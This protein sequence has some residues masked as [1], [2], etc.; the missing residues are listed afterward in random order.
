MIHT[1]A[2]YFLLTTVSHPEL[3]CFLKVYMSSSSQMLLG[4]VD[5]L[6][7]LKK[8]LGSLEEKQQV[9]KHLSAHI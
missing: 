8:G 9:A 5:A 6:R 7:A 1:E 4:R 3:L 2:S